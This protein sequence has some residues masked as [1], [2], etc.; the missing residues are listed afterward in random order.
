MPLKINNT[1]IHSLYIDGQP[2]NALSMYNIAYY[3]RKFSLTKDAN[4]NSTGTDVSI[5]RES[6]P[7]QN[8][9][10]GPVD[11]DVYY[12][13][14]IRMT[15]SPINGTYHFPELYLNKQDGNGMVYQDS[16]TATFTVESDITY[17]SNAYYSATNYVTVFYGIKETTED[18]IEVRHVDSSKNVL[19]TGKGYFSIFTESNE[20]IYEM[21]F[22]KVSLPAYIEYWGAKFVIRSSKN[23]LT[24]DRE[25]AYYEAKNAPATAY[26]PH[27]LKLTGVW[28]HV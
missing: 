22:D 9:P 8:A 21:S 13:D 1:D 5:Y 19:I 15:V 11:Q 27:K 10:N 24:I 16:N 2:I 14:V 26:V 23:M 12:G 18:F 17:R 6:S 25:I 4:Y 20:T 3:G 28:I 7:F